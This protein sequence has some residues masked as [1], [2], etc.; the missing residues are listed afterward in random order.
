MRTLA[1]QEKTIALLVSQGLT[2]GEIALRLNVAHGTVRNHVSTILE[3][4]ELP[5][6]AALAVYAVKNNLRNITQEPHKYD[7]DDYRDLIALFI[8]A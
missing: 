8:P 2:N 3:K 4:L 7:P 6:R 1:P 5:N